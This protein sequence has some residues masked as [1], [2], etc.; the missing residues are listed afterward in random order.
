M[1]MMIVEMMGDIISLE[2]LVNIRNVCEVW[3]A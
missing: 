2:K 3:I 1:M